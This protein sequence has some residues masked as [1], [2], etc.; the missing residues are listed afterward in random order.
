MMNRMSNATEKNPKPNFVGSPKIL[1]QSSKNVVK[2]KLIVFSMNHLIIKATFA[3][4]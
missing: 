4:L 1:A 2:L 3:L